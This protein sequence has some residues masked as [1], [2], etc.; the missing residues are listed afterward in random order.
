MSFHSKHKP[1]HSLQQQKVPFPSQSLQYQ[2]PN[3]NIFS[4]CRH[5][6]NGVQE[7]A[8]P[9]CHELLTRKISFLLPFTE[10]WFASLKIKLTFNV[11]C[12]NTQAFKKNA[13]GIINTFFHEYENNNSINS[14]SSQN[15]FK[16]LFLET[17]VG[18]WRRS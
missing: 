3:R 13:L 18:N 7:Q 12:T 10:A 11:S 14:Y 9:N 5:C 17:T 2:H 6:Y 4:L 15:C 1:N 8:F 16:T